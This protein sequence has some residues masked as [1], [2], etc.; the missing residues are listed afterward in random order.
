[1]PKSVNADYADEKRISLNQI[2]AIKDSFSVGEV[3]RR[4]RNDDQSKPKS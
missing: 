4:I 1:M 2:L 3:A